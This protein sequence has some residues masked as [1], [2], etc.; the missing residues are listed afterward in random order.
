MI[1]Q[2]LKLSLTLTNIEDL[3]ITDVAGY[4]FEG[5]LIAV[6]VSYFKE[7]KEILKRLTALAMIV[8]SLGIPLIGILLSTDY[9]RWMSHAYMLLFAMVLY[10]IYLDYDSGMHKVA[11]FFSKVGYGFVYLVLLLCFGAAIAPYTFST[12]DVL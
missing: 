1:L 8:L 12:K 5:F 10:L 4:I 7:N 11:S 2:Q 9:A 3:I 6:L